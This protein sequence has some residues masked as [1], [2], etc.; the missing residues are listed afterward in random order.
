MKFDTYNKQSIYMGNTSD[1]DKKRFEKAF[2]FT[3]DKVKKVVVDP[4]TNK[5]TTVTTEI[6]R[7][8]HVNRKWVR[9]VLSVF[10]DSIGVSDAQAIQSFKSGNHMALKRVVDKEMQS[11]LESL[12]K[13]LKVT[14]GDN[15]A[16]L[17]EIQKSINACRDVLDMPE[18][19]WGS[20]VKA[21]WEKALGVRHPSLEPKDPKLD[22]PEERVKQPQEIWH[23]KDADPRRLHEKRLQVEQEYRVNR[24]L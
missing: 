13:K 17:A 9:D 20:L 6:Q 3:V 23:S 14:A 19:T 12:T 10:A 5:E 21:S 7:V 18:S 4:K 11:N 22:K 8:D 24:G 15:V 1:F 2:G 16:Q